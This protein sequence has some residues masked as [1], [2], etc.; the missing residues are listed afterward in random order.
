MQPAD[1][2]EAVQQF[3][4]NM[5]RDSILIV[6]V[7][8]VALVLGILLLVSKPANQAFLE[9]TM[10]K[11]AVLREKT[12]INHNTRR[13]RFALDHK[14]QK[15]G[16]PIGQ[17]ITF[18]FADAKGKEVFRPYTPVSDDDLPGFVDFVVKVYPQGVMGQHLDKLE[19]GQPLMMKGPRGRFRYGANAVT[20]LGGCRHNA[21]Q[22]VAHRQL[23]YQQG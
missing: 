23:M 5:D 21:L 20:K 6:V 17:H 18:R 13:F 19:I 1:A 14:R 7:V 10:F 15:L 12:V 4:T 9:P 8:S 22:H 11:P 16:L 3:L 2:V